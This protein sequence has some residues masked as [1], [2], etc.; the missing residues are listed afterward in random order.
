MPPNE[1]F[2]DLSALLCREDFCRRHVLGDGLMKINLAELF[3]GFW[4]SQPLQNQTVPEISYKNTTI[5]LA[6]LQVIPHR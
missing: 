5:V 6:V 1:E 2:L 3:L 4:G